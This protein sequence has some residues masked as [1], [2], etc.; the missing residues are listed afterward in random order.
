M[1]LRTRL[2]RWWAG[3][4][5][6]DPVQ[7]HVLMETVPKAMQTGLERRPVMLLGE[8]WTAP[9]LIQENEDTWVRPDGAPVDFENLPV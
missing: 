1:T 7:P 8:R 6:D 3:E 5:T 9:K 4:G 2:W